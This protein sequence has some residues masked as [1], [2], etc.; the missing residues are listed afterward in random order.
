MIAAETASSVT[1]KRGEGAEDV[2]LR[3]QIDDGGIDRQVADAGGA[4]DAADA[5]RR[6]RT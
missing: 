2:V 1:L 6:W 4:G 5:S 3:T